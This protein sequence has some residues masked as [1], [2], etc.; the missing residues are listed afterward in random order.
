MAMRLEGSCQC[1]KV[2]FTVDS[3]TPY[4]FMYCD[5][6]WD[7]GVWPN[8]CALDTPLPETPSNVHLMQRFKPGWVPVPGRG[9]RF[10]RY[11]ELSIADWHERHGLTVRGARPPR[12]R[13]SRAP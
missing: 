9:P 7:Y 11:P 5:Q 1:G 4:P 10:P 12:A 3:E 13:K 6:R 2:G 8:A